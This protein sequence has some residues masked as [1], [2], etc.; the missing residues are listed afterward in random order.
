[1]TIEPNPKGTEVQKEAHTTAKDY[2]MEEITSCI[3]SNI[4]PGNIGVVDL[5]PEESGGEHYGFV[6]WKREPYLPE[7]KKDHHRNY[8]A[9]AV[10]LNYVRMTDRKWVCNTDT[11]VSEV[12]LRHVIFAKVDL[13]RRVVGG[14]LDFPNKSGV[15][16]YDRR[17]RKAFLIDDETSNKIHDEMARR[18]PLDYE[19]S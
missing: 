14:T 5:D 4:E 6:Q 13:P 10:Y 7:G 12:Q 16:R 17:F 19:I 15:P 9:N 18:C 8:V 1:M 2:V 11:T 3:S